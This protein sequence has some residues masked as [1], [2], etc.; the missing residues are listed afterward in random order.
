MKKKIEKSEEYTFYNIIFSNIDEDIFSQLYSDKKSHPNAPINAMVASLIL[1]NRNMWIGVISIKEDRAKDLL[2]EV[3]WFIKNSPYADQIEVA[4]VSKL[5][6]KNGSMVVSNSTSEGIRGSKYDLVIIDEAAYVD[7]YTMDN[8]ILPTVRMRG[9][10]MKN[11]TPS[12]VMMSTPAS[13][14]GRYYDYF[15]Q[16]LK[17]REIVC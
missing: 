17:R 15:I 1:R 4:G 6:I 13:V 10:Y 2:S 12:I 16:G 3:K 9:R 11:K 14:E 8:V 7:D 5:V